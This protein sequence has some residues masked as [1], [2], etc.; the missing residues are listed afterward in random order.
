MGTTIGVKVAVGGSGVNVVV[1]VG[2]GAVCVGI[3]V[4]GV[5]TGASWQELNMKLIDR[6]KDSN[7]KRHVLI[8]QTP[9]T[10]NAL[11]ST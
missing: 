5:T 6:I 1:K 8:R 11:P 4:V 3:D 7:R 9:L 10:I 2:G